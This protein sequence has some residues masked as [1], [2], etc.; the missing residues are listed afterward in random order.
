MDLSRAILKDFAKMTNNNTSNNNSSNNLYVRGTVQTVGN[1]KYVK[2]DGSEG[3]TPIS[4][5]VDVDDEDRVLVAIENHIATIIGNFT[6]PPSARK[7]QEALDK[8]EDANNNANDAIDKAE[9]ANNNAN[10][11]NNKAEEAD[12]K[13]DDAIKDATDASAKAE[14]AKKNAQEAIDASNEAKQ[15]AEDA[16]QSA[17]D[18]NNS[19]NTAI[20]E[21]GKAQDAVA[22]AKEEINRIEGEVST[23]KGD[24]TNAFDELKKQADAIE[25][26][27]E[28]MQLNYSTKTET[29]EVE[30]SLKTEISKKVGE[31]QTTVEQTY[32]AKNDVVEMEGKL[33]SQ[34]TQNAEGIKSAVSKTEKLE[35]DTEEAQKRVDEALSAAFDSQAAANQA[36]DY[37]KKSQEAANL[38]KQ[39]SEIAQEKAT[40]AQKDADEARDLVTNADRILAEA[41]T[42]LQEA[43]ENLQN[44]IE[45]GGTEEEI[46]AAR[47]K[48]EQAQEVVNQALADVAEA[49]QMAKKAQDAANQAK[50]DAVEAQNVATE[51]TKKATNAKAVADK[52]VEAAEEAQKKVAALTQR[53][54]DAET[55]IKQNADE[56][57]LSAQKTEEIGKR[58]DNLQIGGRNILKNSKTGIVCTETTT[59]TITTPGATITT[60]A[61]GAG[62]AYRMIEEFFT[63][64]PVEL[65]KKTDTEFAFSMDVKITGSFTDL[66][67]ILSFKDENQAGNT[68]TNQIDIKDL[69]VGVWSR[70]SGVAAMKEDTAHTTDRVLFKFGW[71]DSTVDSTIEYRNIQFEEGN[72]A[73]DWSPAPEE[74]L[75]EIED[76]K[77]DLKNNYYNKTETDAAIKVSSDNINLRVEKVEE[78]TKTTTEDL[79]N[80]IDSNKKELENLQN[81]I[82]GSIMTWFYAYAPTT[83]NVPAVDW[84]TEEL[85]NNHLGDLFYDTVTGYCYRW[86][87]QDNQYSWSRVTDSDVTKALSDAAAAKDTADAK[88]RVFV[89][90]PKTPYDIGD[91]WVQGTS[92]DIMRCETA[93]TSSQSYASS[94]WV[95]ASKYTDDSTANGVKED[96]K[97]NY[98][99]KTETQAQIDV[100]ADKITSTVKKEVTTE[101]GKIQIGSRNLLLD[102]DEAVTNNSYPM[103]IYNMTEKMVA[104]KTY[105][106]RLWGKLGSGKQ[107]FRLM[108]DGGSISLG[109][110]TD[111]SDGTYSLTFTGKSGT[112]TPSKLYIYPMP[113]SSS[114][115]STITKIKLEA[116]NK[117]TDWTPAPEEMA[118]ADSLTDVNNSLTDTMNGLQNNLEDTNKELQDVQNNQNE[119]DRVISETK[120]QISSLTQQA[121]GF[122]MD[123]KTVNEI[124]KQVN[125]EFVTEKNERYKY[126]K[127]IDGEIWLGKEVD[128]GEDDFKLVIK[129]DRI[130]FLQNK[131]EVAYFSNNKLH[132]TE[133]H[134]TTSLQLGQFVWASRANGNVGLRW[135]GN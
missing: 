100:S 41:R 82:D 43:E 126:I 31:L 79:A 25:A 64:L 33:Q 26:T 112:A 114:A 55:A 2:V 66:H 54:T 80:Y 73:T 95:K 90:T 70:V 128:T 52:A 39:N 115:T 46:E 109:A 63:I 28:E 81:Q 110:L 74:A 67:T 59:P 12:K 117:A 71:G 13:A 53:I 9:D 84:N 18:A 130:S 60:K 106:C 69:R 4:G 103:K 16:K 107:E 11:A 57:I 122:T 20:E 15:N 119:T 7:E 48:V 129:N 38:A 22:G 62:D 108:L 10:N 89:T 17:Q 47:K 123:F 6:Y 1:T 27:K 93:K 125:D 68:Y 58:L 104:D 42:A 32:A 97:K 8:A 45:G 113:Q 135:I 37:A 5:V 111:N 102:S 76:L 134:V 29:S 35:S 75:E 14:E 21:A 85:K 24:V 105:T 3:L 77:N 72:K 99:T 34:I 56:I 132:V 65:S 91:L 121:E 36:L 131:V 61:T 133:I 19:A 127:F 98:Y 94:D 49:E 96:L 30:A 118:T 23:V 120:T 86:Q 101:V 44:V 88:R 50:A 40:Q 51:A 87:V 124:I 83:L 78:T 92:G 116:G